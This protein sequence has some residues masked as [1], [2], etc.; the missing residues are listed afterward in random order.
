MWLAIYLP[1]LPLQAFSL[2]LAES[3]PVAVYE[4][5]AKRNRIVASNKKATQLGIKRDCSLAQANALSNNLIALPREP[6]RELARLQGLASVVNHLT[7]NIHISESF[8][9]LLDISASLTLFGGAPSLLS[10]AQISVAA[11]QLRAH[12]VIAP[13]ARGA[14]WLARAHRELIVLDR[15]DEWLDDLPLLATDL[16]PEMISELQ[17][18]N[19]HHLAAVR[20]LPSHQLSK[21]VGPMLALAMGQAYGHVVQT[22]PYWTPLT[23][24]RERV[25]FL[26]LAREQ[27]HWMASVTTLLQQLQSYLRQHAAATSAIELIFFHG[28]LQHTPLPLS[29]AQATDSAVQWQRLL[30]AKLERIAIPHEI[31]CI[32]LLCEHIEPMQ[33]AELDF[34]DRSHDKNRQWQSLLALIQSRVGGPSLLQLPHHNHN[35][36]PESSAAVHGKSAGELSTDALRP[37][38]LVEPPRRLYGETLHQLFAFLRKQHPERI[39]ENWTGNANDR[40]TER[41]YYIA[42]TPEHSVWWIFRERAA[43]FW[44]LHGIFA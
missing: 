42:M 22:L 3:G 31:S 12:L 41:D 27:S 19:L 24:F 16:L 38:W 23:H 9:L 15:L 5:D 14:R 2:A 4:R 18:L 28:T 36:L 33:F 29:T 11:Q 30:N 21:R 34:F 35:A 13:S 32:D 25:E 7:P 37:A 10:A 20:A 39:Q 8:G 43:G 17:E 40:P 44:F 1:A 26:D 6:L